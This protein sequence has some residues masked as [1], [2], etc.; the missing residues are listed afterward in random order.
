MDFLYFALLMA[1]LWAAFFS[2]AGH[3]FGRQAG[4]AAGRRDGLAAGADANKTRNQVEEFDAS[5]VVR[6][7]AAPNGRAASK[8]QQPPKP[9]RQDPPPPSGPS[10]P[11]QWR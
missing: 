6:Q 8:P 10:R 9:P 5:Q 2:W 3:S 11:I 4:Y 7:Q 1:V